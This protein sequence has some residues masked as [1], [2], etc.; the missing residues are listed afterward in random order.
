MHGKTG[1][2]RAENGMP[3]QGPYIRACPETRN[4]LLDGDLGEEKEKH[5]SP[6]RLPCLK[7]GPYKSF[8][9]TDSTSE[10]CTASP[11]NPPFV[12]HFL[13]FTVLWITAN[14]VL[15]SSVST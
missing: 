6:K 13:A 1:I 2:S 8:V 11:T 9:T 7:F 3:E 15:C 4:P 14:N 12:Q 10:P 5:G